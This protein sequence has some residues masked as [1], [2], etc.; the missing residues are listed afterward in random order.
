MKEGSLAGFV[1]RFS[2]AW[3][4]EVS[5]VGIDILANQ[6][7]LPKALVYRLFYFFDNFF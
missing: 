6:D 7:N 2:K 1:E 5:A 4:G 3:G